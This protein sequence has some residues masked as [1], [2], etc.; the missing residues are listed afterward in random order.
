MRL[1]AKRFEQHYGGIECATAEVEHE[2]RARLLDLLLE[3]IGRCD[4][5]LQK[6]YIRHTGELTGPLHPRQH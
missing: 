6:R 5:L 4:R 3:G 2:G 1:T